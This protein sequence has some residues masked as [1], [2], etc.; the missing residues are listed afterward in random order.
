MLLPDVE[1]RSK[2]ATSSSKATW[3]PRAHLWP[4]PDASSSVV[5]PVKTSETQ[6][7]KLVS[8]S[9]AKSP[10][11][12]Q[13]ASARRCEK[14]TAKSSCSYSKTPAWKKKPTTKHTSTLSLAT[15]QH[16]PCTTAN[17]R[18]NEKS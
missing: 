18:V 11:L 17:W 16:E 15:V 4:R 14:S 2:A 1:S 12:G 3:V 10:H 8:T 9:V 6:F 7:S 5:M 13:T